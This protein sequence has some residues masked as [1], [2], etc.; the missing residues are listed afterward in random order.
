MKRLTKRHA[1]IAIILIVIII[2]CI[3]A[4]Y[5]NH[6]FYKKKESKRIALIV[7]GSDTDRWEN[8]KR[9]AMQAAEDYGAEVNL[10]TMSSETDYDEQI[11]LIYREVQDG[12]SGI[13]L[14]ACN[15]EK[16]GEY[17]DRSNIR[18]PVVFV[19]NGVTTKNGYKCISAD[20][21][22]MGL[23]LGEEIV[24]REN[25]IIKVAVIQED[26]ERDSIRAREQGL[27]EVIDDYANQ[28]VVWKREENEN[29]ISRKTFLQRQ[30]TNEAVDVIV[31]LDNETANALIDALDNLNMNRKVYAISNS[32]QSVY[33]LDQQRIKALEYQTDYGIGYVG[34]CEVLDKKI[35]G[36]KFGK[37]SIKYKVVDKDNMYEYDNQMLL[38]P[39]V[40]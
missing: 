40:K 38:F 4:T 33:Y 32:D 21:Y 9:G 11:S 5:N 20:D 10:I 7:Y 30:L 1:A 18:I 15:S 2:V 16:I 13:M 8:M 14:A 31:A 29:Y 24:L 28:V 17:I 34:A 26:F 23:K 39:F 22:D 6:D 35:F 25:P 36:N 12:V 27:R 37:N 3:F 19:E